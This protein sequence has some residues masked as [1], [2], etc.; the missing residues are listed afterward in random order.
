MHR[1]FAPRLG[2][3]AIAHAVSGAGLRMTGV[4]VR[5]VVNNPDEGDDRIGRAFFRPRC[6]LLG[7]RAQ[8]HGSRHGLPI[9]PP[10]RGV[11]LQCSYF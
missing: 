7:F 4:R 2:G 10:L 9:F 11:R 8:T 1:F 3:M 6:G 5:R